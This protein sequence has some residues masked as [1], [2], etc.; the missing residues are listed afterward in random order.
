MV[1]PSCFGTPD[2]IAYAAALASK[3][4]YSAQGDHASSFRDK[5]GEEWYFCKGEKHHCVYRTR[6]PEGYLIIAFRGTADWYD[7]VTD[8]AILRDSVRFLPGTVRYKE[9]IDFVCLVKGLYQERR[10]LILTGHSLGGTLA[11]F[12]S[13]SRGDTGRCVAHL[14]NPGAGPKD[15]EKFRE[16]SKQNLEAEVTVHKAMFDVICLA[17]PMPAKGKIIT[18][19]MET[20][21]IPSRH[22][23]KN[24]V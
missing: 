12:V 6:D 17:F 7:V 23:I 14:F 22:G 4:A 24:F 11:F 9:S 13:S 19:P 18:Y 3:E 1:Q 8:T 20:Q 15:F 2:G 10:N 5:E 16:I 21:P